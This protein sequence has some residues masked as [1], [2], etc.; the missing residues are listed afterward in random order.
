MSTRPG[1]HISVFV[2]TDHHPFNRLIAWADQW[3]E[4]NLNDTVTV[5]YGHSNPPNLAVGMAFLHPQELQDLIASS[6]IVITHGGP[7]TI[8]D[9]RTAGH[10][11]LVFPR[12][13]VHGEHVD[14]HQQRFSRWSATRELV[15]CV[16][17]LEDLG[18]HVMASTMSEQGT[19]LLT[20]VK[21]GDTSD[22]AQLLTLLLDRKR[23][24]VNLSSA[25]APVVL[26]AAAS[27]TAPVADLYLELTTRLNVA[28]IGDTRAVWE[29]GIKQN[30]ACS[31]GAQFNACE[32]WQEVGKKAFGGWDQVDLSQLLDL[33][34]AVESRKVMVRSAFKTESRRLRSLL[35]EYSEPYYSIFSA[36]RDISGAD[37][38][39]HTDTDAFLA[40]ALSHN[41][42]IDLRYL[43]MQR[44]GGSLRRKELIEIPGAYRATA[45]WQRWMLRRRGIPEAWL[46]EGFQTEAPGRVDTI[47]SRLGFSNT[48]L[49][50]AAQF[51]GMP[52]QH[53]ISSYN[54]I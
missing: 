30:R 33:R 26:Y 18:N 51:T 13:P 6:D 19:R 15:T 9:A 23:Q 52:G 21:S 54:R 38:V 43:D 20:D 16:E 46:D 41:R 53:I 39:L 28:V 14:D 8:A 37:L 32:F 40:L 17:T 45:S 35:T 29:Q 4:N 7:A 10:L 47:W 25:G 31:C 2:G 50:A 12:D 24:E 3:S 42:E 49:K 44:I 27:S 1:R 36:V 22:A 48:A 11:P 5:Q 34:K